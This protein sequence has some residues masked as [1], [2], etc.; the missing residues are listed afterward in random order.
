M[1]TWHCLGKQERKYQCQLS[2]F[3]HQVWKLTR[4]LILSGF[5]ATVV[6]SS[7]IISTT[8]NSYDTTS[9]LMELKI[10]DIMSREKSGIP[11]NSTSIM[12][13]FTQSRGSL[14]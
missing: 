5:C 3:Q 6:S 11:T 13:G 10:D 2:P 12:R 8:K 14:E 9:G 7:G 4:C 1:N